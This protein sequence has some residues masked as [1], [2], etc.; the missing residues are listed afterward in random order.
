MIAEKRAPTR[1]CRPRCRRR[2]RGRC[3]HR[4]APDGGLQDPGAFV[5][6]GQLEVLL[7]EQALLP[8]DVYAVHPQ[9]QNLA[10]KVRVFVEFLTAHFGQGS[11]KGRARSGHS[12]DAT[13]VDAAAAG[14]LG[15]YLPIRRQQVVHNQRRRPKESGQ[16]QAIFL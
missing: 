8:A 2:I 11:G 16:R 5:P 1:P 13:F 3:D 15:L 7:D 14:A 4:C 9:G 6:S 10:A 12:G